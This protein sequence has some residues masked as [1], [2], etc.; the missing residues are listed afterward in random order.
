[1][2]EKTLDA[3]RSGSTEPWTAH[4][5]AAIVAAKK[6]YVV[7]E[8]GTYL[9]MTT[10][11]IFEAMISYASE[12]GSILTTVESD[13][14]RATAAFDAVT[15]WRSVDAH[16]GVAVKVVCGDAIACIAGLAEDSV[17]LA[18]LDDD[19]A[20][21]HVREELWAL[22]PKMRKGGIVLMHD[23]VG[24]FG[25]DEVCRHA[26]GIVLDFPRLHAAGGLGIVV[27]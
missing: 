7:L 22:K 21:D 5:I 12:H 16:E 25:L 2:S 8:T 11:V 14:E 1:M 27:R 13:P 15:Q 17:D 10:R 9:G 3:F 26:G 24:P 6:P 23:V 4:V 19:H 20:A 18:F